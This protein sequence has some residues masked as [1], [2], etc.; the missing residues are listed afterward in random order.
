[1][2]GAAYLERVAHLVMAQLQV[3]LD[4]PEGEQKSYANSTDIFSLTHWAPFHSLT[5]MAQMLQL[6]SSPEEST[7]HEPSGS[8]DLYVT[9]DPEEELQHTGGTAGFINVLRKK[10]AALHS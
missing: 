7:W 8:H 1:M 3:Q 9:S 2:P 6:W 5:W 4:D 10:G